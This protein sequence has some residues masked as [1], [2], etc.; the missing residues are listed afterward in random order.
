MENLDGPVRVYRIPVSDIAGISFPD[1]TYSDQEDQ[2]SA[3]KLNHLEWIRLRQENFEAQLEQALEVLEFKIT[4][5]NRPLE[6]L[7]VSLA[8]FEF[9]EMEQTKTGGR[10]IVQIKWKV[11]F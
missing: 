9:T 2:T 1:I 10:L 7:I 3:K 11:V 5:A 6:S 4:R 8:E